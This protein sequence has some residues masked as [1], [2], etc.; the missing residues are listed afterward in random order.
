MGAERSKYKFKQADHTLSPDPPGPAVPCQFIPN[1]E[2]P[3]GG[4]ADEARPECARP[5]AQQLPSFKPQN[6]L[7]PPAHPTLLRPGRPHSANA[8]I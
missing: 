4:G 3:D 7:Q 2:V 5:R 1:S 8:E 6:I